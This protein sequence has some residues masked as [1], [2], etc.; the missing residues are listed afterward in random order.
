MVDDGE[1]DPMDA[2]KRE[3]IEEALLLSDNDRAGKKNVDAIFGPGPHRKIV[4]RGYADDERNT[5]NAWMETMCV[6]FKP[7]ASQVAQLKFTEQEGETLRVAWVGLDS[8]LRP[9]N[10]DKL[11]ASHAHLLKLAARWLGDM[12]TAFIDL[13]G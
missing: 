7:S 12:E 3:F 11:F 5:D 13:G 1:L 8:M 6:V 2:C 9:E 10:K 4:F